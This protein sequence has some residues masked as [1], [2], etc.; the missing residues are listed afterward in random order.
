MEEPETE[1]SSN[2]PAKSTRPEKRAQFTNPTRLPAPAVRYETA[3]H[4]YGNNTRGKK[5]WLL[6][7]K[8]HPTN[9]EDA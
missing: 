2:T 5:R 6:E 4:P 8:Q 1:P 3:G 7:Q 9:P